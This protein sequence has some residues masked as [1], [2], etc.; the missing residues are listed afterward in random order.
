[1]ILNGF[2]FTIG[3]VLGL[4]AIVFVLAFIADIFSGR[5]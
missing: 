1:M 2:L 5:F 4:I 3:A